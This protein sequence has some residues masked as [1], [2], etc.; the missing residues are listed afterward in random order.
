MVAEPSKSPWKSVTLSSGIPAIQKS[1]SN[2]KT[3]RHL[4]S[5]NDGGVERMKQLLIP[6]FLLCCSVLMGAQE[7]HPMASSF[8]S[9]IKAKGAKV[10]KR[11]F[12]IFEASGPD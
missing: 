12:L 5:E 10:S 3:H 2:A 1:K 7:W 9:E 8:C 4:D 11:P 6:S